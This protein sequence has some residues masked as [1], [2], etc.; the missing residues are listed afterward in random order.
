MPSLKILWRNLFRSREAERELAEELAAYA[1]LV[2]DENAG[3]AELYSPE[4][5]VQVRAFAG[6]RRH[7]GLG[8]VKELETGAG[9]GGCAIALVPNATVDDVMVA[10]RERYRLRG[11]KEPAFYDFL[12]AAGAEVV[13]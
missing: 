13:E 2:T 1:D 7:L 4:I 8:L 11:F 6:R 12:P 10:V 3:L 9:F 5:A